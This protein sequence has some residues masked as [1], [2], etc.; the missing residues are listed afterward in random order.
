MTWKDYW[1]GL[2]NQIIFFVLWISAAFLD[3]EKKKME[4]MIHALCFLGAG[5]L[6]L[7]VKVLR[8]LEILIPVGAT[9]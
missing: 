8:H 3:D 9:L 1:L 7:I 2:A 4:R 5:L 6:L